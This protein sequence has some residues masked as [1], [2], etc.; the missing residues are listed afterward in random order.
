MTVHYRSPT[1]WNYTCH[2]ASRLYPGRTCLVLGGYQLDERVSRELVQALAPSG[3]EAALLAAKKQQQAQQQVQSAVELERAQA[4]Y[5]VELAAERYEQVDPHNRLVA[6]EL[7]RRWEKELAHLEELERRL[8]AIIQR[9]KSELEPD[10]EQLLALGH[11]LEA[12]WNSPKADAAL[13]QRLAGLLL[14]EVLCDV[15][16][17]GKEALL[18]LHWQGG[19][20]SEV[21]VRKPARGHHRYHADPQVQALLQEH[22]ETL[23]SRQLADLLNQRGLKTGHGHRWDAERV[24]A[25]LVVHQLGRYGHPSAFAG[26][27]TLRAAG[28]RLGISAD[29]VRNLV[30]QG[31]LPGEQRYPKAFYR[32]PAEALDRPEVKAA[33]ESIHHRRSQAQQVPHPNPQP[34]RKGV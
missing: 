34:E 28:R 19:R 31:L 6:L 18:V 27:L 5:Q 2:G 14:E 33:V 1:S 9:P 12:V 11:N 21:R 22:S 32:I 16:E 20:H 30:D 10:L 7:E 24:H 13:K 4:R 3:I 17:S 15:E 25:F 26:G 29:A 8:E 23:S